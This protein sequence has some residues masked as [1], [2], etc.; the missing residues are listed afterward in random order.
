MPASIPENTKPDRITPV[1]GTDA[2]SAARRL[3]RAAMSTRP[4]RARRTPRARKTDSTRK[5]RHRK[6]IVRAC[7]SGNR[8]HRSG[9][10][11]GLGIHSLKYV[12]LRK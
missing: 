3:S 5:A 10:S 9:R 6:Y 1:V 2:A 8:C 7:S 11:I 12:G 4:A